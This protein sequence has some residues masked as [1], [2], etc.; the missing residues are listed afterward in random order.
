MYASVAD[1]RAEGVTPEMA[2]NE[3]LAGA[4]DEASAIIDRLTGWF[5]EPRQMMIRMNGRGTRAI[6]PPVPP[7]R[8]DVLRV[9]NYDVLA[10]EYEIEGA[11]VP[12]WFVAPSLRLRSGREFPHREGSIVAIGL[13]GY[14]EPDGTEFG[15]TPLAIRR[16]AMI[17]ALQLLP[18]L[19]EGDGGMELRQRWR[20]VEESTRDQS[21][22][23]APL[24]TKV[25][26]LTGDVDVD[27]LLVPY[28][29]PGGLGA[30]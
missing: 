22:R 11:P 18:K 4:L 7:I 25:V 3:R 28:R 6:E 27:R 1:L 13:W 10:E 12:P 20:I 14:T 19:G 21:Y 15:R 2:T 23:L 30:A 5:F 8:I 9:A 24:E 16:A 26:P 29:R 17:L